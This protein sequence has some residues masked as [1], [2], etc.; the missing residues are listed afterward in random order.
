MHGGIEVDGDPAVLRLDDQLCFA[1]YAT[2]NA[3]VRSYRPLLTA[4]GLTYPQYLVL[5]TLWQDD[6]VPVGHVGR[7]LDLPHH[8]VGPVLAR[9]EVA[10]LVARHRDPVDRRTVLV[11]LTPA[12]AELERRAAVAQAEVVCRTGLTSEALDDLRDQLHAVR[13]QLAGVASAGSTTQTSGAT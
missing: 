3:V 8:A 13:S 1:L 7:R 5:M 11:R 10:G 9:L 6:D 12:G 2:T 4:L